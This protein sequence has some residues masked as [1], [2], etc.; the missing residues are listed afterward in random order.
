M[1]KPVK[2]DNTVNE[3]RIEKLNNY[4]LDLED[5]FMKHVADGDADGIENM[6]QQQQ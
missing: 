5:Q 2:K 1:K 3:K 4:L 6:K